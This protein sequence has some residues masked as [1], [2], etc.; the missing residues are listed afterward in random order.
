M[1][2]GVLLFYLT[3]GMVFLQLFVGGTVVFG[4]VM[5]YVHIITGFIT[6]GFA[7]VATAAAVASKPSYQ[8]VK[9][10]GALILSLVSIQGLLGFVVLN[11]GSPALTL[12]HFTNALLIYGAAVSGIFFAR[13][14]A[15]MPLTEKQGPVALAIIVAIVIVVVLV[16][17]GR[18]FFYPG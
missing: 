8:P 17:I 12:I 16:F 9:V 7:A 5:T 3:G 6:L 10:H 13:R 1:R 2:A 11:T 4:F 14:W 15:A 18:T